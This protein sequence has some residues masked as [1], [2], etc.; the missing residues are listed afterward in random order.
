[1]SVS[2]CACDGS[3]GHTCVLLMIVRQVTDERITW[4]DTFYNIK[5]RHLSA[6]LRIAAPNSLCKAMWNGMLRRSMMT[7]LPLP[8][9]EL[10]S[11][12]HVQKLAVERFSDLHR[13][14][15]SMKILMVGLAPFLSS[16][17]ISNFH[18]MFVRHFI[19]KN[20]G[21]NFEE[22]LYPA[23]KLESVDVVCLEPGCMKHF[24]NVQCLQAHVKSSHQ[25][26]TCETCGTKQLKKNIKRH[27]L[28]HE[29]LNSPET[30]RCEFKGCSCTFSRV[31][32]VILKHVF[33]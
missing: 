11:S 24:T 18:G 29:P 30:F 12:T 28:T 32:L 16:V 14:Y 9:T 19:V 20:D 22:S 1:M 33:V 13:S 26:I 10:T 17:W 25:Y 23:V 5:G 8:V 6:R 4:L 2:V 3:R 7:I 21:H 27:L 31:R 15:E